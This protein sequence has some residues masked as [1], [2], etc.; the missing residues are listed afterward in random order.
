MDEKIIKSK[1][2]DYRKALKDVLNGKVT[3]ELKMLYCAPYRN[4][5]PWAQFP[6]WANPTAQ[7]EGAHE[8]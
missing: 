8:G 4:E 3:E 7:P 2:P 6:L 1:K 5:V